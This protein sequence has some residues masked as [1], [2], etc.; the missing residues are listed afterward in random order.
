MCIRDSLVRDYRRRLDRS[1]ALAMAEQ[2][3]EMAEQA[4]EAKTRFLATL[5]HEIRTPMTGVLGMAEL[6]QSSSL[7]G[8]QQGQVQA[9][10]LY[11]SRCV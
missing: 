10:L 9:C 7:D 1:H 11:T 3:R 2:Q 5:G 8:R 4:S 6:L